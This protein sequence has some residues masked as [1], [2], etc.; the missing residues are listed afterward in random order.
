MTERIF[1]YNKLAWVVRFTLAIVI[2][3]NLA[4]AISRA[5]LGESQTVDSNQPHMCVHTRLIDEVDEWKI[6]RSLLDVREMGT[7]TIVEFFPW[8]YLEPEKGNYRWEQADKIVRHAQNQG[9]HII[10][11]TGFVPEWARGEIE[12][13]FTTLNYLPDESFTDFADFV[14]KFAE[15]YAGI[16]DHIIVWNEPNLAFEWGYRQIRAAD[17]VD[18]L[19]EVYP[20]TKAANP[21]VVILAGAMA[22]TLEPRG[23]EHGLN[24]ILYLEDMYEAGGNQ[25]F[26]ALAIHTYGFTFPPD[27]EPDMN[28]LNFRR[29]ELLRE[30]MVRYGD[31][32]T[33]V[34]ITESGWNDNI[35]WANGV[36]PSQRAIYTV[37]AYRW[38]AENWQWNEKLC[39]WAL[40]Y[41]SAT[42][43]YPD[44]FTI[45][46]PDFQR[47]PIYFAIQ[48]YAL[49]EESTSPL[50]LSPPTE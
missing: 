44:N 15:R 32:T 31:E 42:N 30:V 37:D 22:P 29:A 1:P 4:P 46:T 2:L 8:A 14:A 16:I 21:D 41:P 47:K 6:Q 38:A 23:S 9:I 48:A 5:P 33:P 50:W 28:S 25:W 13:E 20:T 3:T 34:F 7:D 39:V 43:S 11:R 27:A 19:A 36:R 49:G 24:D 40:R 10:A 12:S 26:D 35:R 18:L 17:Y 45:L